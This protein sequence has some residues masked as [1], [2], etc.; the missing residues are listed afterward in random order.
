MARSLSPCLYSDRISD[1]PCGPPDPSLPWHPVHL[2]RKM[3]APALRSSSLAL[4]LYWT[5]TSRLRPSTQ[6]NPRPGRVSPQSSVHESSG[7]PP[8]A[9]SRKSRARHETAVQIT[10]LDSDSRLAAVF[11]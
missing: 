7:I 11:Q 10:S 1:G 2:S 8:S 4:A 3:F 5:L 9:F 6:W